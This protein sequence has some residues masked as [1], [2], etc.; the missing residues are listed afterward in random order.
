M[1]TEVINVV[2]Q[3]V[4]NFTKGIDQATSKV[5]SFKNRVDTLAGA[6]TPLSI[7]AGA[8]L[9]VSTK[10]AADF[11]KSIQGAVRGLDL[12]ANEVEGF[13]K[14]VRQLS[15]D[16]QYQFS[17]TELANIVTEAG[18]LGVAK[19]DVD[20][21]AKIMAKVAVATDQKENIEKISSNA[22]KIASVYKFN[23]KATE[24]YLAA[25]N[26]LD[27][28]TSATSNEILNFTQRVSGSASSAKIAG[29]QI[30]AF[31]ATLIS[32][33]KAPETAATFMNKYL[34]VLGAATNLSEPAQRAL[35]KIGYSATDLSKR[36]D[37]DAIGTMQE[38][39]NRIKQLDTVTQ[40]EILG[41]IFGQEHVGS[42]QLLVQQTDL[43]AKSLQ[44][45]GNT[46]GNINKLNSEFDK[47][48]KN[49]FQGQMNAFNN[50]LGELGITIGTAILPG[51]NTLL[52]TAIIPFVKHISALVDQYPQ[53]STFIAAFLGITAAIAP[54][55]MLVSAIGSFITAVPILLGGITAVGVGLWAALAPLLPIIAIIGAIAGAA[56]LIYKNWE[57]IKGF[58]TGLWNSAY[59][60]VS[61]FVSNGINKI[62]E[63]GNWVISL[64]RKFREA[65]INWGR[66]LIQGFIDGLQSMYGNIQSAMDNFTKWLRQYLP[67]SDA[68][69][70]ALSDLTASGRSMAETFMNG[71]NS[72]DLNRGIN[73]QLAN[74]G[75]VGVGGL[76][77][78]PIF[79]RNSATPASNNTY[80][81]NYTI[82]GGGNDDLVKQLKQRD[83]DLL[84]IINKGNQ[85]VNRRTY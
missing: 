13:R 72:F 60:S 19:S 10:L 81:I 43:L 26:K 74:R 1:A 40:R 61:D 76:Q 31:G 71:V 65:A 73:N 75:G 67:S 41:R 5:V 22:A 7:A 69:K 18:K 63:F 12:A 64:D 44:E 49:S 29:T 15:A 17:S 51:L 36:F 20:D 80:N 55:L 78:A 21:F 24:E 50:S 59:K 2:L 35:L 66:G 28:A 34:S 79:S 25:V 85:R 8:A 82:N 27:D 68:K 58:F 11:D 37:K 48:A 84:D 62:V 30:A 56:Y 6:F 53:L 47:F 77:P 39:L 38:F 14:S 46:T 83:R 33:G 54:F 32:S 3:L 4:N 70:G 16:L 42:A 9:G 52:Q 23:T 45:A 57:P